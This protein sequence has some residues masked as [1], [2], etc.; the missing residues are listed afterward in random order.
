MSNILI[1]NGNGIVSNSSD[2]CCNNNEWDYVEVSNDILLENKQFAL[3]DT[4]NGTITISLPSNP[5]N[6][7]KIGFKDLTGT[8]N[9]NNLIIDPSGRTI[10]G[11]NEQL[12]VDIPYM[13][14]VL[15]YYNG[16]WTIL[17]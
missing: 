15:L 12:V 14:F 11:D 1:T 2:C 8:W 6:F 17:W 3:V 13:S 10:M 7:D 5:N 4:S 9:T 16:N